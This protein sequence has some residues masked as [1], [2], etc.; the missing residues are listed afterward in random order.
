MEL[1]E[2]CPVERHVHIIGIPLKENRVC[3]FLINGQSLRHIST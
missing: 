1:P 2:S 3:I